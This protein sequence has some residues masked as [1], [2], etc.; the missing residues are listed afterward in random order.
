MPAGRDLT[1]VGAILVAQC[2]QLARHVLLVEDAEM[3]IEIVLER[4][5]A[6]DH[7]V[8]TPEA[9]VQVRHAVSLSRPESWIAS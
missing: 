1:F 9:Q 8:Q 6:G 5:I 4:L 7:K 3:M 2:A